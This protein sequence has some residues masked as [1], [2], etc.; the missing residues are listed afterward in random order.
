MNTRTVDNKVCFDSFNK[1]VTEV[2]AEEYKV[3]TSAA[4]AVAMFDR[5]FN[6]FIVTDMMNKWRWQRGN[7]PRNPG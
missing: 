5:R 2:Y 6:K 3:T 7:K 1:Q 4:S